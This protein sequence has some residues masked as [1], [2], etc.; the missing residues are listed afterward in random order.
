[1]DTEKTDHVL[2]PERNLAYVTLNDYHSTEQP[3]DRVIDFEQFCDMDR[4]KDSGEEK[5]YN[6][7]IFEELLEKAMNMMNAQKV[8]HDEIEKIYVASMDFAGLNQ[9]FY[10]MLDIINDAIISRD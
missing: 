2:I 5:D 6:K 3:V 10:T 1:L 7:K 4:L 8:V 9:A